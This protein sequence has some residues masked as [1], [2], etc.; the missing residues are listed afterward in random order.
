MTDNKFHE[1]MQ[2]VLPAGSSTIYNWESPEQFL[3]VM[4]GMDF[5]I[6]NRL[7]SIILADILGVPSI[8]INAEPPKIL[9]YL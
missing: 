7:H 4:Q 6:G 9:D 2:R 1:K 5:H 8:G 3:E